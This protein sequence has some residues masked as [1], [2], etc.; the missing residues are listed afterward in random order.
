MAGEIGAR[1]V[2]MSGL[3]LFGASSEKCAFGASQSNSQPI[4]FFA[5]YPLYEFFV[6]T[7]FFSLVD[8]IIGMEEVITLSS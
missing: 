2:R 8:R 6:G 7:N 4:F 5:F 1:F 3:L